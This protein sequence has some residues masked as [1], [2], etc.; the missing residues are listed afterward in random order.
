M[1]NAPTGSFASRAETYT[2]S[3]NAGQT[4]DLNNI[5][6]NSLVVAPKLA[7]LYQYYRITSVSMRIKPNHDTYTSGAA[8]QLPYLYFLYDK[9]GSLG[10]IS[11][12]NFIQCGA[13]PVRVDDKTI[14]RTWK[15]SVRVSGDNAS[16]PMF[17]TSPW[18]PTHDLTGA[19]LNAPPH[20][21]AV[22]YIT[23]VNPGDFQT[24]LI[25]VTVTV[26]FRKPLVSPSNTEPVGV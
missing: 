2:L 21:G 12:N 20:L 13:K 19:N 23:K 6:L 17:K 9:S 15:P 8:D 10:V 11:G 4:Y 24:Y 5:S 18:M 16:V 3:T 1:R 25:D 7:Q 26:Q 22:W 14:V